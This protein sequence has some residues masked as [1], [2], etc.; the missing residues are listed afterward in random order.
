MADEELIQRIRAALERDPGV[1]PHRDPL[2]VVAGA[3]LALEGEV[4]TIEVKRRAMAAARAAANGTHVADRLRLQVSRER[5]DDELAQAV[6]HHLIHEPAFNETALAEGT[7]PAPHHDGSWIGVTARNGQVRLHGR[8]GS[9]SHRRLAEVLS[10]WTAGVADVDNRIHVAPP[11]E[12]SDD[13]IADAIR[14]V[15]DK[16]SCLDAEQIGVQVRERKV[17][18][19]GLVDTEE[20]RR[21]AS[22]DCWYVAGVHDVVNDIQLP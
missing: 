21:I 12:D 16:E 5:P 10:W 1:N 13:E 22:F 6:L 8:T 3:P 17:H 20:G 14:L 2:R 11:E 15:L 19:T 9:L 7:K 18:L 4:E